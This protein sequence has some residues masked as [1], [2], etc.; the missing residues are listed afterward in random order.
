LL[1]TTKTGKIYQNDHKIYQ[2]A[3]KYTNRPNGHKIYQLLS[4]QVT[5]KFAPIGIFG[6][7]IY[8]LATLLSF[9]TWK[10][11]DQ[12]GRNFFSEKFEFC[13]LGDIIVVGRIF[14]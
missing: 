2:M 14:F 6:L 10:Q 9:E 1:G 8:Y 13:N 11:C 12:I 4:L 5:R 3:Q 7:K